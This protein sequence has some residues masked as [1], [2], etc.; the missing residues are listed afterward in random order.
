M[1]KNS[2]RA[3]NREIENLIERGQTE[4]AIAHCKYIL[5][6][7]PK[8][9]DTYRLLGK[10]YL[11]SQRYSEAADILQRVLSSIPDDFVS[12]LGMSII[13][14]DEGNLDAAIWHM[15]RAFEVQPA[16]TAI[17]DELRRLYGRRDGVEPPKVRL[18][19]GA[20]VRMYARGELF[21]QAISEA[22]AAVAE[23]PQR[24]DLEI[25]LARM[26]YLA[27]HK[28]EATEVCSRLVSKLPYCFEANRI[29]TDI[30]PSTSRA[31]DAK[32]FQQNLNALDP[33]TAFISPA[34]P[35]SDQVPDQAVLLERLDWT[36]SA[37]GEEPPA[38]TRT[39]GVEFKQETSDLPDWL[40][41]LAPSALTSAPR[42]EPPT[43][44]FEET[45]DFSSPIPKAD[46]AEIPEWMREAG[47]SDSSGEVKE[48]PASVFDLAGEDRE[49]LAEAEL[50]SW[51]KD[52]APQEE[53]EQITAEEQARLDLLDSILPPESLVET[54]SAEEGALND[55]LM[56]EETAPEDSTQPA[57]DV[58]QWLSDIDIVEESTIYR[59]GRTGALPK[60]LEDE[61]TSD[62]VEAEEL[63]DEDLPEWLRSTEQDNTTTTPETTLEPT[64]ETA[65]DEEEMAGIAWLESLAENQGVDRETLFIA[66]ED[67]LESPP[68]WV[69]Q[70]TDEQ[71]EPLVPGPFD[72]VPDAAAPVEEQIWPAEEF[73][74]NEIPGSVEE[75]AVYAADLQ[76]EELQIE[77]LNQMEEDILPAI[78]EASDSTG[79]VSDEVIEPTTIEEQSADLSDIDTM[80]TTVPAAPSDEVEDIDAALAWL[81]SL[82][83]KQGAD[84]ETLSVR[85]EDRL[86]SPPEWVREEMLTSAQDL[87]EVEPEVADERLIAAEEAFIETPSEI[88][89]PEQP[90]QIETLETPA[91]DMDEDAAFAWLE[92]L[93]ARQGAEEETL[94]TA[95]DDRAENPPEWVYEQTGEPADLVEAEAAEKPADTSIS[96]ETPAWIDEIAHDEVEETV[97]TVTERETETIDW[98]AELPAEIIDSPA[99]FEP[100][101]PSVASLEPVN[102]EPETV[103]DWMAE[104]KS[105]A[106]V[107]ET[108]EPS[109]EPEGELF[110]E[111]E[112]PQPAPDVAAEALEEGLPAFEEPAEEDI[113]KPVRIYPP[114]SES[115]EE[116]LVKPSIEPEMEDFEISSEELVPQISIEAEQPD[117]T[118]VMEEEPQETTAASSAELVENE[119]PGEAEIMSEAS[120]SETPLSFETESPEAAE[121]TEPEL[122]EGTAPEWIDETPMEMEEDRLP[123]V[124]QE[125]V[126]E[127]LLS[128]DLPQTVREQAFTLLD[129]GKIEAAIVQY[130]QII[131]SGELLDIVIEDLRKA[132]DRYPVDIS[133]WQTLGDAYLRN[134]QVQE[135][136]DS[137]T[138]AEELLR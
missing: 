30:L 122:A 89:A 64:S 115:E 86:E 101:E 108:A 49:E 19:R 10:T 62:E 71:Q 91:A 103:L 40:D 54:P 136:L 42:S 12:Q 61:L 104:L 36:P 114:V 113:T 44:P 118:G 74:S 120:E 111:E 105:D 27:G 95:P 20:L 96:E 34:A 107:L 31:E 77:D 32:T 127:Q 135:A 76:I 75:N 121:I 78:S 134:D 123:D 128:D 124:A 48:E 8:H 92:S 60:W 18:T 125:A 67:P 88:E 16:N 15:E 63:P 82:A 2:L 112:M 97:E 14:E 11:E 109:I 116:T 13:R 83:Q 25:I 46:A 93:A 24:I 98:F 50:P 29:L 70:E 129:A 1:A 126:A 87:D 119:A 102:E 57:S 133:I 28:V 94:L 68:D 137:Y 85:P 80:E 51:L 117:G 110:I 56:D 43:P 100:Q 21:T 35:T 84:E 41:T 138:K 9:L 66:P 37:D 65:G 3:Y 4:E 130:N 90:I 69:I 26:Y 17:Q 79:L 106:D 52:M 38:W 39:A 47:W 59:T 22:R 6:Q 5:K 53:D 99:E 132:L 131:E 73:S 23:D 7:Y 81:E 33:Y 72:L 45:F 58:P 55:A